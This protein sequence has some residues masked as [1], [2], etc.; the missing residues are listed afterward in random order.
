[1]SH[2]YPIYA[3]PYPEKKN[4]VHVYKVILVNVLVYVISINLKKIP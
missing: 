4:V 2:F 3:L 1:M